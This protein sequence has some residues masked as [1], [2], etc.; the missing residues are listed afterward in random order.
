VSKQPA[1]V[2]LVAI[3]RKAGLTQFAM[4]KRVGAP[5]DTYRR[6]EWDT[7]WRMTPNTQLAVVLQRITRALGD[8]ITPADWFPEMEH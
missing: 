8:E 4:A 7:Q 3:R 6:F 5:V 1:N 2:R